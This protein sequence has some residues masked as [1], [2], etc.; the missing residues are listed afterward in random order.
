MNAKEIEQLADH[1][2]TQFSTQSKNDKLDQAIIRQ[3]HV[4][5]AQKDS[6]RN[7]VAVGTGY[8]KLVRSQN[9]SFL[10]SRPFVAFNAPRDTLK[11]HAEMLEAANQ[12]VWKLSG[13]YLAWLRAIQ[14]VVDVGRGWLLTHGLP[15]LWKGLDFSQRP[16]EPDQEYLDR[17]DDL[18]LANWPIVVRHVDVRNT[19]PTFTLK[20]ELDQV[21]E[22][23][24]MTARQ[25][26]EAYGSRFGIEK[27]TDK[28]KVIVYADHVEMHTVIAKHDGA[29][30]FGGFS[31]FGTIPAQ[32]AIA[33]WEHG[34]KM[35]PYVLMEAPVLPEND[36]GV[37]WEGSIASL[38][39]L[40]P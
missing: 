36:E 14:D 11:E 6:K 30:A 33:P 1:L 16:D 32:D 13:A 4:L 40:V 37:V 22:L 9:F 2:D 24:E 34:M 12:G 25:L 27:D 17:L 10:S 35:N 28:V 31:G 21:V 3:Q 18:K 39:Y 23:R 7:V 15:Q 19:W 8:G 38:R 26:E 5:E 29:L 20:R